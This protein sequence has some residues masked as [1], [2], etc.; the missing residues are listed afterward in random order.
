MSK[1][2][3][4]YFAGDDGVVVIA[5]DRSSKLNAL[6][7]VIARSLESAAPLPVGVYRLDARD[8]RRSCS[9]TSAHVGL[10]YHSDRSM[11]GGR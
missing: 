8:R 5:V 1:T 11:H 2:A 3:I 10:G 9:Q 6:D 7:K 4:R